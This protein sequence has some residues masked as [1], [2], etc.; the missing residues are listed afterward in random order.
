MH[1]GSKVSPQASAPECQRSRRLG[2]GG[3][4]EAWG[5]PQLP[6]VSGVPSGLRKQAWQEARMNSDVN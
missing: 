2:M 3:G 5:P 6:S 4:E 1:F